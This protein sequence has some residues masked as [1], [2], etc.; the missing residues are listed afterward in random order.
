M[1]VES[2]PS[3]LE[4]EGVEHRKAVDDSP[5]S[6][7]VLRNSLR[8][9]HWSGYKR[10]LDMV[11]VACTTDRQYAIVRSQI[12]DLANEQERAMETIVGRLLPSGE[13]KE[14][15]AVGKEQVKE[16]KA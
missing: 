6:T 2:F 10:V 15:V 12:L 7:I 1:E 13:A 11:A 8:A 9:W 4:G 3:R 14:E 16:K 5:P